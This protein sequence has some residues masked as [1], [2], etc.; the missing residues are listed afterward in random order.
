MGETNERAARPSVDMPIRCHRGSSA[1]QGAL[2]ESRTNHSFGESCSRHASTL[3]KTTTTTT[4]KQPRLMHAGNS[5]LVFALQA[6]R[7]PS[8]WPLRTCRTAEYSNVA[9][10]PR[11]DPRTL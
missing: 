8:A 7:V 2:E 11:D 6:L 10:R 1:G 9:H 4:T 5:I 3:P